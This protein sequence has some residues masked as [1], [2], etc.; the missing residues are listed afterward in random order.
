MCEERKNKVP[1]KL[2]IS[3]HTQTHTHTHIYIYIYIYIARTQF[4]STPHK[5][6]LIFGPASTVRCHTIL[7]QMPFITQPLVPSVVSIKLESIIFF[8]NLKK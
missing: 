3:T 4:V 5:T 2:G 6:G 1:L 7:H 8:T